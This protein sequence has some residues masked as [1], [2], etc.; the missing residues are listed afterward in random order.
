VTADAEPDTA[1]EQSIYVTCDTS[2]RWVARDRETGIEGHGDTFTAALDAM[3][4]ALRA[5]EPPA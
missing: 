2:G 3:W 4:A 5:V 1:R